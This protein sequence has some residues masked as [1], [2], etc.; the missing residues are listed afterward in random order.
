MPPTTLKL[1]LDTAQLEAWAKAAG[2]NLSAWIRRVCDAAIGNGQAV[3]GVEDVPV[4]GGSAAAPRGTG[5]D[6]HAAEATVQAPL[7]G[8]PSGEKRTSATLQFPPGEIE[9]D[10]A[11]R[12]GHQVGCECFHCVQTHRFLAPQAPKKEEKKPKKGRR[13]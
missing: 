6:A 3:R 9:R 10:V 4:V 12:T 8:A 7:R 13:R 11:R 1:R 5:G 2:G